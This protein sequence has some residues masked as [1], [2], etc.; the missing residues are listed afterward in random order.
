LIEEYRKKNPWVTRFF[1]RPVL[2]YSN[3][4]DTRLRFFGWLIWCYPDNFPVQTTGHPSPPPAM[5]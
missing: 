3:E 1:F 2:F 4:D 5:S